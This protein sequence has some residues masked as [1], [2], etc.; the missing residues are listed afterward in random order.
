MLITLDQ[1]VYNTITQYILIKLRGNNTL[2]HNTVNAN[3]D[4]LQLQAKYS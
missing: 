1:W 3:C 4:M 2:L